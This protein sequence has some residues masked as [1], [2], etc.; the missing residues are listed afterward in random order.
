MTLKTTRFDAQNFITGPERQA[1]Y[2]E[3]VLEDGDPNLIAAAIGDSAR[4]RGVTH[5]ARGSGLS[6]ETIYKLFRGGGNPRVST[7]NKALDVL[8]LRLAAIPKIRQAQR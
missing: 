1:G 2:I 8:S 7:L 6:R 5:F 3:A 4:A